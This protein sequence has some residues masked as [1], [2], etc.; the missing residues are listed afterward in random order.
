MGERKKWAVLN[1]R[2]EKNWADSAHHD[3]ET[4]KNIT[5]TR[6]KVKNRDLV[7]LVLM[8]HPKILGSNHSAIFFIDFPL[9]LNPLTLLFIDINRN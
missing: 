2:N 7:P 9:K 3:N 1:L 8:I 4:T 5:K 6:I